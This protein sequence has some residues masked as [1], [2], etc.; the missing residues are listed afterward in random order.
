MVKQ[1]TVKAKLPIGWDA[2]KGQVVSEK[3]Q[4]VTVTAVDTLQD[5]LSH[6]KG[7]KG[8]VEA[9]NALLRESGIRSEYSSRIARFKPSDM[10]EAERIERAINALV[11]TGLFT[12]EQARATVA[13]AQ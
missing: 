5:A 6:Y 9:I 4:N 8:L 13:A 11:K 1:L 7:E 2:V 10:S 12:V 3:D